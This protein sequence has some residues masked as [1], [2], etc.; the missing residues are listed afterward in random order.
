MTALPEREQVAVRALCAKYANAWARRYGLPPCDA[1]DA[2]SEALNASLRVLMCPR[3]VRN[4]AA[5]RRAVAY[6]AVKKALQ[7]R[8]CR[9]N[10]V[11]I[12]AL[13][14]SLP[15]RDETNGDDELVE[16]GFF[17]S[18]EG[19][20]AVRVRAAAED[21][22]R[23]PAWLPLFRQAMKRQ[24]GTALKVI[25]ALRRDSRSGVALG[26]SGLPER[27]FYTNLKKIRNDFAQCFRAYR[28][29]NA[30]FARQ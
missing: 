11:W 16:E 27:T 9:R 13:P 28:E 21:G 25:R 3:D 6:N 30:K 10:Q 2:A 23:E 18:D 8:K 17:V 29:W 12:D 19:D 5:F 26:F 1:E 4:A 14:L 20:G 15:D 24:H 7:G 22:E